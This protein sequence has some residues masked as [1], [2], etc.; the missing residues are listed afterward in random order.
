[1][2]KMKLQDQELEIE[3]LEHQFKMLELQVKEKEQEGRLVELKLKEL[4]RSV[5]HKTL[6]PLGSSPNGKNDGRKIY[7]STI[8][9]AGSKI[10]KKKLENGRVIY[11]DVGLTEENVKLHEQKFAQHRYYPP[12]NDVDLDEQLQQAKSNGAPLKDT[13]TSME[14]L[15]GPVLNTN[16]QQSQQPTPIETP[17]S[18]L[19]PT[20]KFDS[21]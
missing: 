9:L 3:A 17:N 5:K 4:K 13:R 18:D 16:R 20:K 10:L 8:E 1:M 21:Q 14:K 7:Q 2:N 11:Q 19:Q 15:K 6:K 12:Q